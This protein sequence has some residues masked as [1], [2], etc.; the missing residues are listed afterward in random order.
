MLS[1]T[2]AQD[3]FFPEDGTFC[4]L[5]CCAFARQFQGYVVNVYRHCSYVVNGSVLAALTD[6]TVSD[7]FMN[8]GCLKE[9]G[10]DHLLNATYSALPF[11][12]AHA[13]LLFACAH[14]HYRLSMLSTVPFVYAHA[15]L[16]CR[17]HYAAACVLR[18]I[19][20]CICSC[21]IGALHCIVTFICK[22]RL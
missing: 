13:T 19:A 2:H 9:R 17:L 1:C 5:P 7:Q 22:S 21:Y 16:Y 10:H 20:A 15:T 8:V 14:V 6:G 12:Y 11:V 4:W 18:Y 3:L